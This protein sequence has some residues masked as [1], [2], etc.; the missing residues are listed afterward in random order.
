MKTSST[1]LFA[2]FALLITS[3][4]WI[5]PDEQTPAFIYI[6]DFTFASGNGTDSEKITEVWVFAEGVMLGA[7]SVPAKVPVLHEGN[8]SIEMRAGIKNN[9]ISSTRIMYPFYQPY[10]TV[11][12]LNPLETDTITPH[13]TFKSD[14]NF[15]LQED[16]EIV[17][18]TQFETTSNSEYT[19]EV[20]EDSQDPEDVFEGE[21]SAKLVMDGDGVTWQVESATDL[22]LPLG[23]Q[24]WLELN[25]KCNNTFAIGFNSVRGGTPRKDLALIVNRTDEE[26]G[27]PEWNKIYVDLSVVGQSIVGAEEVYLYIESVREADVSTARLWFDNIRIVHF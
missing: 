22:D 2:L 12:N 11:V 27:S 4:K 25:Y 26:T 7:Y 21:R 6:D 13:F 14:L 3:C 20:V 16:F 1:L 5:D 24:M 23:T 10:G 8:V 18:G 19:W 15:A 9:G 17:A